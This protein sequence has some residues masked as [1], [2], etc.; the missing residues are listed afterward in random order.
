VD[1]PFQP[2]G[3]SGRSF[4]IGLTA[5]L[6]LTGIYT[7]QVL[8]W[9]AQTPLGLKPQGEAR[10]W[11]AVAESL[12]NDTAAHEPFFRAPAYPTL[13][14]GLLDAGLPADDLADAAR[15]I[16]GVAHLAAT[17]LVALLARRLWRRLSGALLA[18]AL[19]GFYPPAVFLAAEPGPGSLALLVWLIGA[20]AA[21]GILWL[22]PEWQG[23]RRTRRHFWA[24][25]LL[26]GVALTLAAV[27]YSSW[28]LAALAWPLVTLLLG[29][30]GR[31]TRLVASAA[32]VGLVMGGVM[33]MQEL[34]GGTPQPLAGADLYRLALAAQVT[35]PWAAPLPPVELR[36]DVA[37]LDS[38]EAEAQS[39]YSMETG[40]AGAGRAVLAG[41]WWRR[42]ALAT[43]EWP[44]RT[45]LRLARKAYQFFHYEENSPGAD[46]ARARQEGA[47]LRNNPLSW[48]VLLALGGA[49]WVLGRRQE[50]TWLAAGLAA[51][52]AGGALLWYPTMEARMPAA[53]VLAVLS[54]GLTGRAWPRKTTA[55]A[56][57]AA[58]GLGLAFF[59]WL[60]RPRDE[61]GMLRAQ[62]SRQRAMAWAAMGAYDE[63][64][65]ELSPEEATGTSNAGRE[66]AAKWQ[67]ARMLRAL[68][69]LPPK[70]ELEAQVLN[71]A[72]MAMISPAAQFR[73]GA[74]LWLLGQEEGAVF[75]WRGM[76]ANDGDWG[77]EARAAL[78]ASG[79]E[80]PEEAQRREAW[81]FGDDAAIDPVILPLLTYERAAQ[82]AAGK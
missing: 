21:L 73:S 22:A 13:L 43:G 28:W 75:Y 31:G 17:G 41:Y 36:E 70:S 16:N 40:Q 14:A 52:A 77:A 42:A 63:A 50:A 61:A 82:N 38:L 37:G 4:F 62:D 44:L 65:A 79:Q 1:R 80:T 11:L 3:Q 53:V 33:M 7:W 26:A 46:Y 51:L 18:G 29:T 60:P 68:P 9:W 32:G 81:D 47:A 69:K 74:C 23:G 76:A 30:D 64:L 59:A 39:I 25:P 66:L 71:N 24:Y 34:W 78:A 12:H 72:D 20:T 15:A 27:L 45:T 55:R 8:A 58:I 2:P 35:Q 67:F 19:W 57:L 10:A 48:P 5:L 6:V 49:G 56:G 54:S